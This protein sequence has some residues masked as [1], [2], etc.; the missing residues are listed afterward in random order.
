MTLD[1]QRAEERG[2]ASH[3]WI[4]SRFSFSFAEYLNPD[5]MG[6]GVLRVIN[7]DRI[8]PGGIFDMH[9]HRDMEIV[10]LVTKGAL[11][12]RDSMGHRGVL[13]AG[14]VQHM[15]AGSGIRHSEANAGVAVL[16]LFQIWIYPKSKSIAPVY[17]QKGFEPTYTR[18]RFGLLVSPDGEAASLTMHQD[19]RIYRG[20]Y[21]AHEWV[22]YQTASPGHGLYLFVIEGALTLSGETLQRRDAAG[23]IDPGTLTMDIQAG[24]DI[25]LFDLP[26]QKE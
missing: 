21:D 13:K 18:N 25:L 23:I 24:S 26:M 14:E 19:A 7:D 2:V 15:S 17:R 6:F 16:E 4:E 12:H 8:L 22:S 5:R 11:E 9:P 20:I 1:I 3:S 10:T